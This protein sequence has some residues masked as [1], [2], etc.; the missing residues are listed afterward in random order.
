MY[1]LGLVVQIEQNVS[2]LRRGERLRVLATEDG[3]VRARSPRHRGG[4]GPAC[5]PV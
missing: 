5:F 4:G 3:K 1:E 2:G